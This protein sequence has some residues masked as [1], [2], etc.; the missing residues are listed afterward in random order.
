MTKHT[1]ASVLLGLGLIGVA[2]CADQITSS[3][4]IDPAR[5]STSSTPEVRV[6]QTEF[7]CTLTR[8]D[9]GTLFGWQSRRLT[10]WF[11]KGE[12]AEDGRTIVYQYWGVRE[13]GTLMRSA[14]CTVPDTDHAI[15]RLSRTFTVPRDAKL[16]R[17]RPKDDLQTQGC[18]RSEGGCNLDGIV[19]TAPPPEKEAE[20]ECSLSDPYCG[21]G[22]SGG[23]DGDGEWGGGWDG[24]TGGG[25]DPDQPP[26]G[27][28]D[29]EWNSLNPTEKE[30]CRANPGECWHVFRAAN[31][32]A[33]WAAAEA[34]E[35]AH[36]GLQD[37]MR[38]AAWNAEMRKRMGAERAQAWA[39]AHELLSADPRETRMDLHNNAWGRW[40]WG[41]LPGR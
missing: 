18:V 3:S 31:Y 27:I 22:G 34:P 7:S 12:L 9:P 30:M 19:V 4:A 24:G 25:P 21:D 40:A 10:V 8:R 13:D 16:R 26:E 36:N 14:R 38:H 2:A 1:V 17:V 20:V 23:T 11:P 39:D 35:G 5:V 15:D 33:D 32:A 37:A 29:A 28:T 41:I 6:G